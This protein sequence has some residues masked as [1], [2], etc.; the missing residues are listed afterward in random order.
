MARRLND[1]FDS[2]AICALNRKPYENMKHCIIIIHY[3]IICAL[4][5]LFIDAEQQQL[6]SARSPQEFKSISFVNAK[7]RGVERFYA[8]FS[9]ANQHESKSDFGFSFAVRV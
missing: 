5:A 7:S 4:F 9:E 8:N 2:L 1:T 3:I 6:R